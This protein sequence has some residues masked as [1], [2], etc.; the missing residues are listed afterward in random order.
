MTPRLYVHESS[1]KALLAVAD[2]R[3]G[4]LGGV[5]VVVVRHLR[6]GCGETPK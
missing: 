3:R 2:G 6:R 5:S 4:L 1:I